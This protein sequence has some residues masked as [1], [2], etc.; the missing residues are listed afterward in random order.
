MTDSIATQT[1]GAAV[2]TLSAGTVRIGDALLIDDVSFSLPAG[3]VTAVLGQNGSGKSTLVRVLARQQKLS[4]GSLLLRGESYASLSTRDF[5]QQVAYLP[6]YTPPTP[7]L[8]VEEVVQLG[9]FPWHGALGRFSQRDKAAVARA[10]A[11]T[12]TEQFASRLVDR[13][14]G[15]ERQRSWIAMLLAQEATVMLLDEPIS[16]LDARFQAEIMALVR[17]V[18]QAQRLSVA[19]VL[20]D[21]NLASRYCHQVIALKSGRL[22]WS[23]AASQLMDGDILEHIYDVPMN[24]IADPETGETFA[25]ARQQQFDIAVLQQPSTAPRTV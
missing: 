7:G 14:S 22:A 11:V 12:D 20:H 15:G 13:L 23:G 2:I 25:V 18:A 6:Q 1:T 19:V 8:T 10:M 3:V 17:A 4:A 9:R 24:V 21:V 16:A 5:S